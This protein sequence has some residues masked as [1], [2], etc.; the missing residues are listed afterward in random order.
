[1]H[2]LW[3]S[4]VLGLASLS[5]GLGIYRS[6][7]LSVMKRADCPEDYTDWANTT[8]EPLSTGKYQLAYQRPPPECRTYTSDDVEQKIEEMKSA[9][10]DPDLFRMF[11]NSYP[12]TLDTTV[13]WRGTAEGS[14]EELTFVITGDINAMWIRDS[15]SQ[16]HSYLPFLKKSSDADS[17]ASLF[18]GLINLQARDILEYPYCNA[19]QPPV[20]S[21][22]EPVNNSDANANTEVFPDPDNNTVFEC[23]YELDS[24]A[25]FFEVSADYYRSTNDTAFFGKYQWIEA[26]QTLMDLVEEQTYPTYTANG[27][28]VTAPYT[29]RAFTNRATET[30]SNNAYGNPVG[31]DTGL[32][33]SAFRPSDDAC[34]YELFVPANMMLVSYMTKIIPILEGLGGHDDLVHTMQKR[35]DD[36]REGIENHAIVN[37]VFAFETDGFGSFNTMDDAGVPSLLA[38]PYLGYLDRD[39]PTYQSTRKKALSS[40]GNP[41]YMQ[42]PVLNAIGSPHIGPGWSWP[43]AVITQILTSDDDEEIIECLESLLNSTAGLGTSHNTFKSPNGR[44]LGCHY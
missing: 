26:V 5:Y 6:D 25:S 1:M 31:G 13:K 40:K 37:G 36:I 21:G 22:L 42:G 30:L 9:I 29:F 12:N 2:L 27:S 11:E 15:A 4:T 35:A 17:F 19:F 20:E 10:A 18:R 3:Q 8:H 41:Y 43:M 34:I 44:L 14:D 38:A 28:V 24:V 23:K 33:R 32:V 39:D 16:L 7:N